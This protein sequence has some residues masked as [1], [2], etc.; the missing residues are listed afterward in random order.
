M[1]KI[2]ARIFTILIFIAACDRQASTSMSKEGWRRDHDPYNFQVNFIREFDVLPVS[3]RIS[4]LPWADT[5][6][7][8]RNAGI[9]NRWRG[10]VKNNFKYKSP[11]A[12]YVAGM[13]LRNLA[14]L[15]PAEKYDIFVG[16]YDYPT[17]K[18]ERMRTNASAKKWE[19]L[20]HG[21]APAALNFLEP[22]A[23]LLTNTDGVQVPFGSSDIKALLSYYQ[24]EVSTAPSRIL[25]SR[26]DLNINKHRYLTKKHPECRGINAGSFHIVLTNMIGL[27]GEGLVVDLSHGQEIWNQPV[28][29]F[30]STVVR[31]QAPSLG[32][33]A[34]TVSEVVVHTRL[35][36]TSEIDPTW[37]ALKNTRGEANGTM[38]YDY[39]LELDSE[40]MIV[41]GAWLKFDR[42]DF[43]WVQDKPT[44]EGYYRAIK[45]I[46][47]HSLQDPPLSEP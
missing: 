8:D 33:D 4:T 10:S 39:R 2:I 16:S 22:Q 32:S 31:T 19:G 30:K 23:V 35:K 24:G 40:G 45:T 9:A 12:A 41:G 21:W 18:S 26:C 43:L 34:N 47:D 29:G 3:G 5:Y 37:T 7:P 17:V 27:Q 1:N 42:P 25:G 15:S 11:P 20:C 28:Y 6:W 14:D 38:D 46:Y 44:F 13:S 36:Y